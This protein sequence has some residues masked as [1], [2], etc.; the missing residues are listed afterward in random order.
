VYFSNEGR[1]RVLAAAPLLPQ[2]PRGLLVPLAIGGLI[3]FTTMLSAIAERKRE[4]YVYTSLGLAPLHVGALFLA[5]A[6]TYGMM[7]SVFGYVAGQGVATF[8]SRLGW[9]GGITLN[10]SGTHAVTVMVLVLAVVVLSSLVP[11]YLGGR[12]AAPS[13]RRSWALPKPQGDVL[14]TVLPFTVTPATAPGVMAFLLEYLDAHREGSIGDFATDELKNVTADEGQRRDLELRA[15]VWLA[16]FDLGVRQSVRI[17]LRQTAHEDA[18]DVRVEMTR[19]SGQ[20]SAW[21]N[22]N[23]VFLGCLRRQLLGWRRVKAQRILE[24][25]A[26]GRKHLAVAGGL[27]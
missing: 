25:I 7:G 9:M 4:I 15:M 13:N 20:V 11:A 14:T 23:R 19:Q 27:P 21:L 12:L 26:T 8:F 3:I 5:E 17:F 24:Y 1:V 2:A 22:L 6:V 18:L 10:Y 16:P